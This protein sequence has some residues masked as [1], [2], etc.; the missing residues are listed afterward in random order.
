MQVQQLIADGPSRSGREMALESGLERPVVGGPRKEELSGAFRTL[1]LAQLKCQDPLDPMSS[2]QMVSQLAVLSG[3][4]EL[5]AMRTDISRLVSKTEELSALGASHL[6]DRTVA[7]SAEECPF[8]G[9]CRKLGL[10]FA[11]PAG[12]SLSCSLRDEQGYQWAQVQHRVGDNGRSVPLS[13]L[14]EL[15][16]SGQ[17][18]LHATAADGQAVP[19]HLLSRVRSIRL[20][21]GGS[22]PLVELQ[23][24][25]SVPLAKV[26]GVYGAERQN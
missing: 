23:G 10:L 25:G 8:G 5:G 18:T 21:G 12:T 26:Q 1:L 11:A 22:E 19:L 7:L 2:D 24:I 20:E 15:P 3:V 16:S 4:G 17:Y 13:E 14:F 6:V 9:D